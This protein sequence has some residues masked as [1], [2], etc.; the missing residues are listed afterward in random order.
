MLS[1]SIRAGPDIPLSEEVHAFCQRHGLTDYLSMALGL[2]RQCF[3]IVGDPTVQLEQD[4]EDGESYLVIEIR[5]G[6]GEEDCA[7]SH[8]RYLSAWANTA[9]WP[10]VHLIRLLY[11]I[12]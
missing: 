3:P 7:R 9:P 10:A 6:G 8:R 2:A 12:I 11:D 4:P 5:A 1:N